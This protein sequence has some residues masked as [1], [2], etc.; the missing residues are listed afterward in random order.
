MR[1]AES[2]PPDQFVEF[3]T[4][5]LNQGTQLPP[6][7]PQAYFTY[8]KDESIHQ[9][10]ADI[11]NNLGATAE[12]E[13]VALWIRPPPPPPVPVA[14]V[15]LDASDSSEDDEASADG[16]VGPA[17]EAAP[18]AEDPGATAA[19]A[20]PIHPDAGPLDPLQDHLVLPPDLQAQ[21]QIQLNCVL[22][23]VIAYYEDQGRT[24]ELA[25]NEARSRAWAH[26]RD[27]TA[28]SFRDTKRSRQVAPSGSSS[29]TGQI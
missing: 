21:L 9:V 26:L 4:F 12:L 22:D 6:L 2:V 17:A 16:S 15:D 28:V 10:L 14:A 25:L 7:A 23:P 13:G 3:N 27:M 19:P 1:R 20:V 5:Y 24:P 29:S 18:I 8:A 11:H